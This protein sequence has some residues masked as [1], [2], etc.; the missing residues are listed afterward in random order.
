MTQAV[1][2]R[3]AVGDRSEGDPAGRLE[4]ARGVLRGFENRRVGSRSAA[5]DPSDER[6][7]P[8]LAPLARLL[9]A[10]GLRRG[11]TV[12]VSGG[13]GAGSL[14]VALLAEASVDGAWV[15]VIGR[16]ELG[17]VAA[18]EAGLRL[19]RL[20]LVPHPG[21]DLVAVAAALLDGLDLVVL[22]GARRAGTAQS[23]AGRT[24]P[25]RAGADRTGAGWA[26]AGRA[27]AGLPA[28]DR[29]RLA[30]RA[31]QRG[32]VLLSLDPWPAADLQLS[33]T[34]ARWHGLGHGR[35]GGAGRL[36]SRQL[37]VHL[38]GRGL[39]PGGAEAELL[40][41]APGGGMAPAAADAERP[42]LS[43]VARDVG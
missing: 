18:A 29:Q 17:V 3:S 1:A 31:R 9:P 25:D 4:V 20:A 43:P 42:V 8:V 32:A 14:L 39:A 12:A 33:C 23:G 30:A 37:R 27:G 5:A 26:G 35:S 10:G 6:V 7:L 28:A 21:R 41:P 11:S 24:E 15:G 36:R 34:D 16:P 19:D 22:A 2:A 38:R 40:L 13:P